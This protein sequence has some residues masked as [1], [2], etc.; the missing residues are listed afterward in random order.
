MSSPIERELGKNSLQHIDN[1]AVFCNSILVV[2][3]LILDIV[4]L[5]PD[6]VKTILWPRFD[7]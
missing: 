7:S 4:W 1:L 5:I 6:R 2:R 3:A